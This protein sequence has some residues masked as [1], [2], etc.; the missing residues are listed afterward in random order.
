VKSQLLS[1]DYE[2]A[3]TLWD[4]GVGVEIAKFEEHDKRTWSVDFSLVNPMICASG[5]DDA[6][7]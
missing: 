3:V 6:K 7:G 1:S 4:T 5:G 2:G